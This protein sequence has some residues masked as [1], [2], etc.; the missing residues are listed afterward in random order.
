MII[1]DYVICWIKYCIIERNFYVLGSCTCGRWCSS[2]FL[3]LNFSV[4]KLLD[5]ILRL[6]WE[7]STNSYGAVLSLLYQTKIISTLDFFIYIIY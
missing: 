6:I 4:F 7:V 3:S 1:T 2:A 5:R